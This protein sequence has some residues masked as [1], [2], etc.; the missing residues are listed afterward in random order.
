[1]SGETLLLADIG[2]KEVKQS[3]VASSRLLWGK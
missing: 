1:M 3:V 2:I